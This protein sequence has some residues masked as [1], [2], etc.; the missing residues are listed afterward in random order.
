MFR[1][2]L[3]QPSGQQTGKRCSGFSIIYAETIPFT[4]EKRSNDPEEYCVIRWADR[5]TF[6]IVHQRNIR[7]APQSI[8]VYETY[9]VEMDGKQRKGTVLLK[10]ILSFRNS[11]WNHP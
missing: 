7:A 5:N 1:R 4:L 11:D 3:E 6:D 9:T 2:F 8:L 10:G